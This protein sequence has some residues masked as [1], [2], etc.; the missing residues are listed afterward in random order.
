MQVQDVRRRTVNNLSADRR[1]AAE[2]LYAG[3]LDNLGSDLAYRK[4]CTFGCLLSDS[5]GVFLQLRKFQHVAGW[6]QGA[7]R[8]K[9]H[10]GVSN[11]N[12]AGKVTDEIRNGI[13]CIC[14]GGDCRCSTQ[15][16]VF[17][18][19]AGRGVGNASGDQLSCRARF[20]LG[21]RGGGS[22]GLESGQAR[23]QGL[24]GLG[25]GFVHLGAGEG[26]GLCG[27]GGHGGGFLSFANRGDLCLV[28]GWDG[29]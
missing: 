23:G 28:V 13:L 6:G 26:F 9:L 27:S 16:V 24:R 22:E 19:G 20:S 17:Q 11:G 25:N 14:S 4:R 21:G 2:S 18:G 29:D 15:C 12:N 3:G 10:Q 1:C 5:D 7:G 8:E